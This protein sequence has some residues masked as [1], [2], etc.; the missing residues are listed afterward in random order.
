MVEIAESLDA[1]I[2]GDF[3]YLEKPFP[4]E[5][6]FSRKWKPLFIQQRPFK[7]KDKLCCRAIFIFVLKW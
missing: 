2:L 4:E 1:M 5:N 6:V 7:F 3:R